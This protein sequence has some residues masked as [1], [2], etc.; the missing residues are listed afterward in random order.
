M[1]TPQDFVQLRSRSA[2]SFLEACSNPEDLVEAAVALGHSSLAMADRDGVSGAPRFHRAARSAGL[3]PL[4]GAEIVVA[5]RLDSDASSPPAHD[6][7]LLLVESPEGWRRLCRLLTLA[8]SR[9][10]KMLEARDPR[11]RGRIRVEWKELE[12]SAG[13][14]S[15]L[16]RG[17]EHLRPALLDRARQVFGNRLSVDVSR[18]LD[19]RGERVTRR[20]AA[21][22]TA[23]R[24][25]VVATGD[26][27]CA[28]PQ[29]RRLLDALICLRER[30]TLETAGRHLPPNGEGHLHSRE[31]IVRRFADQPEWVLATRAIAE[32]CEFTLEELDY[33]FPEYPLR[34]GETQMS[35][36]RE[37]TRIGARE[38][39]GARPDPRVAKQLAHELRIIENLDLSGYFLIVEDIARYAR[40]QK[41]LCQGRGSAANSAVCYALGITAVDPVRMELLFERFL[42]EERGE[43]PDIDIDLPSGD[44][45]EKVIQYVFSKYGQSGSAMTANVI[46]YRIKMAV[47]EMG[48]VLGMDPEAIGRLSKLVGRLDFPVA[49]RLSAS[50]RVQKESQN[51]AN[52]ALE[53]RL[54]EA[55]LDPTSP[56]VRH[57]MDLVGA[58]Q[59]LPRHLGQH[60]G[61][62]VIAAGRLDEVV[63]I[64]PASM[65]NRRIVQWDKDD[66]ADLGIIKIDLLGLGML[67]ALEETI[68]LIKRHEGKQVDL[69]KLPVDDPK[70]Y[71]MM[72]RADTIGVFQIESRAQMATLP[73]LKPKTFYDLVVEIAIIRP[74][75]IV[76]KMVHPY[77]N[78]RAG[79]EPVVYPHESL[80]PILERTLG[81]PIFQEQLLRIAMSAAGFSGGEA[82]ELRRAM[83]FKRSSER[84]IKIEQRL[85]KGMR[86]QGFS[87]EA[88]DQIVLHITSFALYG[89]PESHSASF[90]LIAY[91]SAYLKQHHPA[92]FLVGLLRAQPM[93]F[94][95]PATL[96]KDAQRHG[97]DVRPI[98]IVVSNVQA[99]LEA[100]SQ[101][102]P[103]RIG[104]EEVG[105]IG[106]D[107]CPPAVRIGLDSVGGLNRKTA[108]RIVRER[109][110]EPFKDLG[111]LV[112]RVGPDRDELDALA[113]LGVLARLWGKESSHHSRPSAR[114]SA[115]W[116]V[117]ALER[118][119]DSL[120]AGRAIA[121]PA[122][123]RGTTP[124]PA[125][126]PLPP[127]TEIEETLAD[128]RLSGVTTGVHV[129]AHLRKSLDRRGVL[130]AAKLRDTP[131]GTHVRTAG[132]AIVRQRPGS[133]KGF[134]F[135]TLEDETGLSNA[136]LTP[137]ITKRFRIPL[138]QA[139]LLEIAGRVQRVDGVIHVR[140]RE[141]IPL[142]LTTTD[143]SPKLPTSHD[144]R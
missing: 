138:N 55:R 124:A 91:A 85:R 144:Y 96:I 107:P 137:D 74:G 11:A 54:R 139:S 14:W 19:R 90:A 5:D 84:M 20:A 12:A 69:A 29:D 135:V 28:T 141:I 31:E 65:A 133:A 34:P 80:R 18:L 123:S 52:A 104:S 112:R 108:E 50:N 46:T 15:V 42:S 99:D 8:H 30:K 56:D 118:D 95:S 13:H 114:R 63:P 82:E 68:P 77:I 61:G 75:P 130:P 21:M 106:G 36:L 117:A 2:F 10:D 48:K 64:E 93:G 136:I 126:S 62:I 86:A 120:F 1:V 116:Q 87:K 97:V 4:M 38:R 83:G 58:V 103:S 71:A 88:E 9:R 89:F 67:C 6:R 17:D 25:Q 44:Q 51:E 94:Y 27:R 59:G 121:R 132:H 110:R 109:I 128:Y 131:D 40:D 47:R 16:L 72:R 35:R 57:W 49:H 66:C 43:W 122:A 45:R 129:M 143:P 22:A 39:Y 76:G 60:S 140:A 78:R 33:R 101:I 98:D 113:E 142:D 127:M 119:R 32:R 70:T 134:C 23:H 100:G 41:I 111:D 79:R 37:F 3:R 115:L 73:R 81:V 53:E 105:G 24:V 92:A 7:L 26:V 102:P 125:A